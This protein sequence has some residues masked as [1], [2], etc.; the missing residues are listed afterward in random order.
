[1]LLNDL[2]LPYILSHIKKERN[3]ANTLLNTRRL[4]ILLVV[5]LGYLYSRAVAYQILAEIGVVS[6]LAASQLAPAALGGL[7][8]KRG[9]RQGAMAGLVSGFL[10]WTYT[11]LIPTVAGDDGA[12]GRFGQGWTLWHCLPQAH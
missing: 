9:N 5:L 3:L 7:Y 2:E 6:F 4:N 11:A 10:L 8:W 12:L 1:M